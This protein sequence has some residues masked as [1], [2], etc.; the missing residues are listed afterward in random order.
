MGY[1]RC[2]AG[3]NQELLV[4]TVKYENLNVG[5][6]Y[7]LSGILMDKSTGRELLIDGKTVTATAKFT[8]QETSGSIEPEFTF[9]ASGLGGI[10]IVVFEKVLYQDEE[11]AVHEDINDAS[12]TVKVK[13]VAAAKS[14]SKAVKTGDVNPIM[15]LIVVL[16]I[17]GAAIALISYQKQKK[18][19]LRP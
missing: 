15:P 5:R 1:C 13:A 8:P 19:R 9:D 7:T 12:Q 2:P 17:G 14:A 11:A 16:A 4:D 10:E 6:E 18:E 3:L